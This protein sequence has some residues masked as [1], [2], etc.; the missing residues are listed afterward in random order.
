MCQ[1]QRVPVIHTVQ[2]III[3]ATQLTNSSRSANERHKHAGTGLLALQLHM[4][5]NTAHSDG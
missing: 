5:W 3:Q 1:I 4:P 2:R